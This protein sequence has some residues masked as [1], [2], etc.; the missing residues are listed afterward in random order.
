MKRWTICTA[1]LTLVMAL[2]C[3]PES[4]A[5]PNVAVV[6]VGSSAF[7][8]AGGLAA[9]TDDPVRTGVSPLCGQ[10]F[11]TG[12]ANGIDA[13][14]TLTT[15]NIPAEGGTVWVAWDNDST[16]TIICAYLSVDSIIGQRLFYGQGP[17]GNG[18]LQI[19]TS[20]CTTAG[21]NKVSFIW[22][23]AT[24]GLPVAVYNALAGT[25]GGSCTAGTSA[26]LAHFNVAFTDI[27]TEDA[28]FVG[29]SRV[30][31][32]DSNSSA[33]FPPDDKSCM[34]Y[35]GSNPATAPGVAIKSSFISPGSP[36]P[37]QK[38]ANVVLYS[39]TGSDPISGLSIPASQITPVGAQAGLVFVNVT[40]TASGSG[41]FGELYFSGVS[42]QP[43][44]TNATSQALSSLFSGQS[45]LA[46]DLYGYPGA[47]AAI[48]HTLL[49]EPDS[50]TYTTFEWQIVRQRDGNTAFSQE[51]G[52]LGASQTGYVANCFTPSQTAYP[53]AGNCS[54]PVNVSI[55]GSNAL[56]SRVIGTGEMIAIGNASQSG[57]SFPDALGYAFWSLGNFGNKNNVR[58]LSLDGVDGLFPSYSTHNGVFPGGVSGQGS[59]AILAAPAAGQ[60]GGYFNGDG[61]ATITSF[62]CNAYALP[63]FDGIQAGNYRF[64]NIIQVNYFGSGAQTPSFSPLNVAGFVLS[65][66]NQANPSNGQLPDFL[67]VTY[68]GDAACTAANFKHPLNVFRSHYTVPTWGIGNA[69]NGTPTSGCAEN[70]GDVAGKVVNLQNE[71]DFGNIFSNSF[72]SWVQ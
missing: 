12:S 70:G 67:P 4:K 35:G 66:Q 3:V 6:A 23:T 31:C 10:R 38:S 59:A 46:R 68:C 5:A 56:R 18:Q 44:L 49:R 2:L 30:I 72:T 55:G 61:G 7:F 11:W 32:S 22:D 13:R 25:S 1:L 51:T 69:C 14:A 41:G 9:I 71:T 45:V 28:Y 60:C 65:T 42:G 37:G 64:W 40:N 50:G 15:P 62:S 57:A 36:A 16:P 20:A 34:G 54:N 47:G 29:S 19:P 63:T 53:A 27:R 43:K 48:A 24:T 33:S 21:G 17:G 58:Y 26:T 52:I 8:G 39:Y